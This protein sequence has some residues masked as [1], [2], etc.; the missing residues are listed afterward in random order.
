MNRL[1]ISAAAL[2]VCLGSSAALAQDDTK[3][4]TT[5]SSPEGTTQT[6]T[7]KTSDGYRQYTRTVTATKHYDAGPYVGP[8]GYSYSALLGAFLTDASGNLYRIIQKGRQGQYVVGTDPATSIVIASATG[9]TFSTTSPTL[10]SVSVAGS[11]PPIAST[12]NVMIAASWKSGSASS[13]LLAPNTSW[14]GSNNGPL[15]SNGNVWPRRWP[16]LVPT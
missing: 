5:V 6:T 13:T 2:A 9:G 15:G 14:G 11:V 10:A 1:M 8:S 16:M 12:I 7:T 4:T 3:T